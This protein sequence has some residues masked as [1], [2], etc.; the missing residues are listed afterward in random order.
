[1]LSVIVLWTVALLAVTLKQVAFIGVP[2]PAHT[3][4]VREGGARVAE[5]DI[6]VFELGCPIIGE[7]PF[8]AGASS[9]ADAG[10][11]HVASGKNG[12]PAAVKQSMSPSPPAQ[13]R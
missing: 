11:L 10:L 1:M 2:L 3:A 5:I 8:D 9:P 12:Q 13:L 7:G 4:G 6:E